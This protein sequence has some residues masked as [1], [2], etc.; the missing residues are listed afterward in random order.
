MTRDPSSTILCRVKEYRK[1]NRLSQEALASHVGLRR[2]AVYDMEAGRYLPNTAVALRLAAV[3]GCTVEMLFG[4]EPAPGTEVVHIL[5]EPEAPSS[6]NLLAQNPLP[7]SPLAT[8]EHS[9]TAFAQTR[10][11]MARVRDKLVGVPLHGLQNT[12]AHTSGRPGLPFALPLSDGYVGEDGFLQ[13]HLPKSRLEN[14]A[15]VLGCD[16]ALSLLTG[17]VP[18][19]APGLRAHTAFASSRKALSALSTG[20]THM[21]ATHFHGDDN[22]NLVALQNICPNLACLVVGFSTQEEGLMVAA[23]N[24]LGIRSVTDLPGS[25][26][27]LANREKGAALRKLLDSLLEKEGISPASVRGY[28]SEV[29]SHSEGALCV[30]RGVADAALGLRV[31]AMAFSLDFVPLATTRCDLV[32]PA[33]LCHQPGVA[34]LLDCVQS[35]ALKREMEALPGYDSAAT[36]RVLL[37]P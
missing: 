12:P 11:A 36:G 23:G 28:E 8:E 17:L 16:P 33:D 2:Q 6:Q 21:A 29:L 18:G 30:A 4:E 7:Q 25:P 22:A 10:L 9:L 19:R 13:L 27:R 32:V 3:L 15:L 24:P 34:A 5:G 14:T 1:R 20:H 35:A 37:R 31:V 26:A